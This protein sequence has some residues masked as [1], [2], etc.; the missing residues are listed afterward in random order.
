MNI[1]ILRIVF[2]K[3]MFSFFYVWILLGFMNRLHFSGLIWEPNCINSTN[4]LN[5][6]FPTNLTSYHFS[7]CPPYEL[8]N[9]SDMSSISTG[10][11]STNSQ[12]TSKLFGIWVHEFLHL[13]HQN[14]RIRFYQHW[15]FV[16]H[17]HQ[18]D[19]FRS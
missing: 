17:I 2:S 6:W 9:K 15:D 16:I 19:V 1:K 14:L 10:G 7:I 8:T 11:S 12:T 13:F 4:P 3:W 18:M 5:L